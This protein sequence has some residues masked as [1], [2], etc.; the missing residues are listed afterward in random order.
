M[1][2]L[3]VN[4]LQTVMQLPWWQRWLLMSVGLV[5][6]L[7]LFVVGLFMVLFLGTVSL[8]GRLLPSSWR[9]PKYARPVEP[10]IPSGVCP[11]CNAELEA[12]PVVDGVQEASCP[13]CGRTMARQTMG[14]QW[15]PWQASEGMSSRR[16]TS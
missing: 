10:H 14:L 5:V 3:E 15:S 16:L 13:E 12:D 11:W 9:Q 8:L 4:K 7:A 6:M 1:I 2:V